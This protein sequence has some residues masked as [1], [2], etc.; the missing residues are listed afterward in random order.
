MTVAV[1]PAVARHSV[2]SS[3]PRLEKARASLTRQLEDKARLIFSECGR[4]SLKV[5]GLLRCRLARICC[6]M[7]SELRREP[8]RVTERGRARDARR[9][10]CPVYLISSPPN[11]GLSVCIFPS[12]G[13]VPVNQ[14][15]T[16]S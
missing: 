11:Q 8:D 1:L 13:S 12:C 4:G 10:E 3:M 15:F 16:S 7:R 14:P 5:A 9:N 2:P 6:S